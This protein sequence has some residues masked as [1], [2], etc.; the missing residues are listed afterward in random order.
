MASAEKETLVRALAPHIYGGEAA[1]R[2]AARGLP[3]KLVL[4][5]KHIGAE[6]ATA[7]ASH[8]PPTLQGLGLSFNGIGAEAERQ[9]YDG[10]IVE[11]VQWF[12]ENRTGETLEYAMLPPAPG[13]R[14][15]P[16]RGMHRFERYD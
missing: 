15:A 6:G 16:R 5:D 13:L 14:P 7:I 12:G 8:L 3:R 11:R 4:H 9:P 2:D 1:A 10:I